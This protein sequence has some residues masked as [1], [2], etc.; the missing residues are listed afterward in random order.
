VNKKVKVLL[1]MV[2][3][4]GI[5]TPALA[6]EADLKGYFQARGI[7]YDNLDGNDKA[8]D[9]A[10]GVDQRLRL[11]TNA[12][13]S[14]DVK[15]VLGLE[16]DNVWGEGVGKVGAD[17]KAQLEIKNLY[18]DFNIPG[19]NTNVKAGAQ[20]FKFGGGFI[21]GE[22]A[23]GI[24]IR[25]TSVPN[26][27]SFLVGWV[28]T[29]EGDVK[30]DTQDG[31][32]VHFQYDGNVSGW[33]VSPFV[34]YLDGKPTAA[35]FGAAKDA[36]GELVFGFDN[37]F[38]AFFAGA[39]T[40]GKVGPLSLA[41]TLVVNSWDNDGKKVGTSN[42][43]DGMGLALL[44]NAGYAMGAT[45]LSA[46]AAYY[47]DDDLGT[48][49]NVRGYNNFAELVTGGRFDTR[50][51]LGGN[52]SVLKD[53]EGTAMNPSYAMNYMY[54]KLG[55]EHKYSDSSKVSAYYI[56]AE[57]AEKGMA[58][59]KVKYGHEIDAY[60]DHT[61]TKGLTFTLGGG[62][63]IADDDFGAGDDAWKAGTALTYM[64]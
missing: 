27:Q 56:Y 18:L 63:L 14:E 36:E 35:E 25:H 30:S 57:Q 59:K 12:A 64:F 21:Q 54:A 48:F 10:R 24:Q 60:Y 46:E 38:M 2:A 26:E 37:E 32:Y 40:S 39:E 5:S 43:D 22:D 42:A 16:V 50:T 9:D 47:G 4:A 33:K 20:P 29:K 7:A 58:A 61:I 1:A 15:A 8:E 11:W 53:G 62:Y 23:T 51:G 13:L 34:G 31:D 17:E 41:A 3:V 49:V 6:I 52:P 28:K 45:K 44:V 19:A 55:A